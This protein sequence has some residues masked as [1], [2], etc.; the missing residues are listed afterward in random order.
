MNSQPVFW[1]SSAYFLVVFFF[2]FPISFLNLYTGVKQFFR[3]KMY[4]G[5]MFSTD[6]LA[7]MNLL[8]YILIYKLPFSEFPE[9]SVINNIKSI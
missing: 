8:C 4:S 7:Y 5:I 2:I 9:H 1:K 6:I 3:L